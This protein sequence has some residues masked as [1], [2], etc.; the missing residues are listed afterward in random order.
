[1]DKGSCT[2]TGGGQ[3]HDNMMPTLTI[4]FILSLYGIFLYQVKVGLEPPP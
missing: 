2:P 1:M 3:A 4:N